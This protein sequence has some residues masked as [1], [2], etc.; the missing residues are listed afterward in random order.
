MLPFYLV[1]LIFYDIKTHFN[2]VSTKK[3]NH[4]TMSKKIISKES[5]FLCIIIFLNETPH[6]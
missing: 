6:L 4:V 5:K 2:P 1:N 3:Y